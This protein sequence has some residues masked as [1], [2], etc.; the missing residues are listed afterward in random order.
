MT[1]V[2]FRIIVV[3]TLA[4]MPAIL[5]AQSFRNPYRI[6]LSTDPSGIAAGDLNGDGTADFVW[7][8]GSTNPFTLR[9][10]LSQPTGGWLPGNS[11]PFPIAI[12]RFTGCLLVDVNGDK[13]L[14]LVCA[15][16][17]QFTIYI[18]VFLGNGDGTFQSPIATAVPSQSNGS[19][20]V[21]AL[22]PERDLN[23]D[24]FP[25]FYEV[26]VQ[27]QEAQ[28]LL[29]D[30]KGGFKTPI[31]APSGI[32][33]AFPVSADVNGDGIPDLLFTQ[34][35][36]VALGKGDGSFSPA[37]SYTG[38]SY[39]DATC[40]FHDMDGDGHLDAVCGSPETTTGDITGATDLIILHGNADGSFNTTDRKSV[41]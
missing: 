36:S 33:A 10:L 22:Y 20:A 8:D 7:V 13:R 41:V 40:V 1:I 12:T 31:L 11:I 32:N 5:R 38:V 29:S 27:S 24:G 37:T 28:I 9:V 15:D 30:G 25:D 6:P 26:E 18:H 16:A 19:W 14:D 35:P 23:G 34:G 2:R 21:P 17:Y 3:L 4:L 39:Y